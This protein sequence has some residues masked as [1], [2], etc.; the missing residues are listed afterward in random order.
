[1]LSG[2]QR[3]VRAATAAGL[4]LAIAQ[5][6]QLRFPIF[7]MIAAVIVSEPTPVQ[8]R[9]LGVQ[10]MAGTII[11]ASLGAALSPWLDARPGAE[12]LAVAAAMLVT[13]L[14]HLEAAAKLAG[15]VCGIVLIEPDEGA[16]VYARARVFETLL[17]IAMA[18][19][20]SYMPRLIRTA[21]GQGT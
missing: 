2:L 7:A 1:M 8:T 20:V 11:G 12:A 14:L 21:E 3:S 10:R 17:G 16:W 15:Y 19:L 13:H 4:A 9:R 6:L 5:A 18:L